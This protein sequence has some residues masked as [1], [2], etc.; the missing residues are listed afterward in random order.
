[1]L[2]QLLITNL[3]AGSVDE[4]ARA[5]L[6]DFVSSDEDETPQEKRIR[7]TKEYLNKLENS[8]DVEDVNQ[9]LNEDLMEENGKLQKQ[10]ADKCSKPEEIKF[11]RGH[12]NCVTAVEISSDGS[13]VYSASKDCSIIKW[14]MSD[15]KKLVVKKM[16]PNCS[17][18]TN[19]TKDILALAL[20]YDD[21]YLASGALDNVVHIWN[22]DT[23]EH[24]KVFK[25]HKDRISGLA[26][27][28]EMVC[29][30]VL[31]ISIFS[32]LEP[33]ILKYFCLVE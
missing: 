2:I 4:H 33:V 18:K 13:F 17:P 19:H 22:A 31:C 1:M 15:K 32:S 10:F 24:L 11:F 14:Q 3:I 30:T 7:L 6:K 9:R 16:G 26:F 23:L 29:N 12:K 8:R 25:G 20:S 28:L 21:K 5:D 27:R